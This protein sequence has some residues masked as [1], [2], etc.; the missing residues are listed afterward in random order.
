MHSSEAVRTDFGALWG[1]EPSQ[2]ANHSDLCTCPSLPQI[3][4]LAGRKGAGKSTVANLLHQTL[5]YIRVPLGGFVRQELVR[6]QE[7]IT[8]ANTHRLMA[9]LR[10]NAEGTVLVHFEKQLKRMMDLGE[11]LCVDAVFDENDIAFFRRRALVSPVLM[12]SC[13]PQLAVERVRQRDRQDDQNEKSWRQH[14]TKRQ[15]LSCWITGRITNNATLM[16]L[17][18]EAVRAVETLKTQRAE[19]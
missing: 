7:D 13:S 5:G 8:T 11:L 2:S 6:R 12:V 19:I 3:L 4:L 16:Y 1:A 10:D 18:Q 17:Q 9:E 15:D 14:E